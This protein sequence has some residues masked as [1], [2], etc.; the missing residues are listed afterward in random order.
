MGRRGRVREKAWK[1]IAVKET[2]E[3]VP[4]EELSADARKEWDRVVPELNKMKTLASVDLGVLAAYCQAY[5]RWLECER[6][7]ATHGLTF[8]VKDK[9]GR[10]KF[11]QQF[12][13]VAIGNKALLNVKA[14]AAELGLSPASR[15]RLSVE[16][17]EETEPDE[18]DR[19]QASG[20]DPK[21][22]KETRSRE[23]T[24]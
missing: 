11:V 19:W 14:L 12:P 17:P 7:I 1:E 16:R 20:S 24:Q 9:D 23:T 10:L 4:P 6:F 13:Q 15:A 5:G 8:V 18:F 3:L 21:P 2:P 22:R